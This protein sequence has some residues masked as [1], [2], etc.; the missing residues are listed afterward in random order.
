MVARPVVKPT[1]KDSL[2]RLVAEVRKPRTGAHGVKFAGLD[3]GTV[4]AVDDTTMLLWDGPT[5]M[6]WRNDID[7]GQADL[8]AAR[9]TLAQT[10][11]KLLEAENRITENAQVLA[12]ADQRAREA[13]LLAEST[14]RR[15]LIPPPRPP[16]THTAQHRALS[17]PRRPRP[18]ASTPW[19]PS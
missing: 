14:W 5:A 2:K 3:A 12:Q 18:A 1:Q 16:L 9:E 19:T 15:Q 11:A 4:Y 8:A 10:A 13:A 17:K 7:Q 6:E